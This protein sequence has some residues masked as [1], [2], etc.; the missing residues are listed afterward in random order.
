MTSPLLFD[1]CL[2]ANHQQIGQYLGQVRSQA[3]SEPF[4][5]YTERNKGPSLGRKITFHMIKVGVRIKLPISINV[6]ET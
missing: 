2:L 1:S 5:P 6:T 4:F 3:V